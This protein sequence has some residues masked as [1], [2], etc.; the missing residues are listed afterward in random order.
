MNAP[1]LERARR[2]DIDAFVDLLEAAAQWMVARGIEQWRPGGMR[3]QRGAFIAAQ[4]AGEVYVVRSG[5]RVIGGAVLRAVPDP[6]WRDSPEPSALYLGKLVVARDRVGSGLGTRIVEECE[7]VARER[8]VAWLRL[9]C[10]AT[11]GSLARYYQQLGYYP[12]GVVNGLLRHD[13]RIAPLTG[14]AVG[15]LDAIDFARWRPDSVATLL[16]V[17][18]GGEVLLIRKLRGHGAGKINGPGGMVELGETPRAC[19]LREIEEEVGVVAANATPLVEL[20]FRN[21][22]G[23]S[24]LGFAFRADD[25][26]G[27]A[28]DTAEAVPFWCSLDAVP[29]D[30]M[31]DDDRL[32][33]PYLLDR[34]PIVG[35][36]LMHDDRL[37][38]HRLRP[39]DAAALERAVDMARD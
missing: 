15:S 23:S 38:A 12:R 7:R 32:W 36:F 29:Y 1:R 21:T 6:I 8:G 11:N 28:H 9:D 4:D 3:A 14:V 13:K 39:I 35:E 22:D 37:V 20:R 33:L 2:A 24:M 10:V 5:A 18:R 31:W 17:V 16:F 34:T 26:R 30:A 19:A 27:D 25:C